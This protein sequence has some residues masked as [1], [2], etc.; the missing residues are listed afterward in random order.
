MDR[1]VLYNQNGQKFDV[2]VIRYFKYNDNKYLIFSLGEVDNSG[3]IQ[4]YLS[5][6]SLKDGKEF[7]EGVTDETEWNN[8]RTAIQRIVTNVRANVEVDCDLD[9]KPLDGMMVSEFRIFKLK[10]EISKTLASNKNVI[11]PKKDMDLQ[12]ASAQDTGLTIE[13]ILKEVSDG[14]KNAKN[15]VD[16]EAEAEVKEETETELKEEDKTEVKEENKKKLTIEDLLKSQEEINNTKEDENHFIFNTVDTTSLD[17]E[18]KEYETTDTSSTDY[19][20]KYEQTVEMLR[21]LEKE[22][23]NLI[24]DLVETKA[25]L[26]MIKDI[27]NEK[28]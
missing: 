9:Y 5:K 16:L 12:S 2:E 23:I 17:V 13:Q 3:Y 21:K 10:E 15:P 4:L 26:E 19:K 1:I 6:V 7:M 25:K 14:A 8:F 27:L 24:N 22:N 20:Q 11:Q 18:E 28:G